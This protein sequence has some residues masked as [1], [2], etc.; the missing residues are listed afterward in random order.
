MSTD[1]SE[2][3]LVEQPVIA[4]FNQL[5]YETGRRTHRGLRWASGETLWH[6]GNAKE[7]PPGYAFDRNFVPDA[8]KFE[9]QWRQ[10]PENR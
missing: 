2:D 3:A 7:C 6:P 4:L 9:R 8:N 5:G 1:D 10:S